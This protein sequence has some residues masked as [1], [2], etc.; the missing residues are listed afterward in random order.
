MP[1]ASWS[2][3]RYVD[4]VLLPRHPTDPEVNR[5]ATKEPVI[6]RLMIERSAEAR[7]RGQLLLTLRSYRPLPHGCP[8]TTPLE[9]VSDRAVVIVSACL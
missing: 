2:S 7:D 8:M 3:G 1:I 4:V 6:D 5:P 9:F